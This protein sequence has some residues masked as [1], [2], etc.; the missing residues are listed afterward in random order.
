MRFF[1]M[2]HNNFL[3]WAPIY[4]PDMCKWKPWHDSL[5]HFI[6]L[7]ALNSIPPLQGSFLSNSYCFLQ[8]VYLRCIGRW[9]PFLQVIHLCKSRIWVCHVDIQLWINIIE[10]SIAKYRTYHVPSIGVEKGS[11][12]CVCILGFLQW[13]SACSLA[14][15]LS[16]QPSPAN[17]NSFHQIL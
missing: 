7:L 16:S 10:K 4:N 12:F 5:T 3:W 8:L 6:N 14:L 13:I 15:E 9:I 2:H 17:Q 1:F 11:I